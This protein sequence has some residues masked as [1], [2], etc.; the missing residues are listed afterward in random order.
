MKLA[1]PHGP[2]SKQAHLSFFA[3]SEDAAR[4]DFFPSIYV[5]AHVL[6]CQVSRVA[7][8]VRT[9]IQIEKSQKKQQTEKLQALMEKIVLCSTTVRLVVWKVTSQKTHRL[10]VWPLD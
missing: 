1:K 2:T 6:R 10:T 7:S 9:S 5:F 3:L 8:Q 4:A